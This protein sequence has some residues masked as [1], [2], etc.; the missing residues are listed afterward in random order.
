MTEAASIPSAAP[1][2]PKSPP[3]MPALVCVVDPDA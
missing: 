2:N 3:I 1:I